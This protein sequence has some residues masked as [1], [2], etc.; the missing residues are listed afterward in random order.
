[1][2]GALLALLAAGSAIGWF[3]WLPGYRPDLRSG[4]TLGI[5][6]SHHQGRIDWRRVAGDGITFAYMKASEGADFVD[7]RFKENWSSAGAA[8]LRRGAY[9][10]FSLCSTGEDQAANFLDV[11]RT[12]TELPP[13]VDLEFGPN[14]QER[15][16]EATVRRELARYMDVIE[17][18]I[19]MQVILY[20]GHDFEERYPF[21]NELDRPRWQLGFVRRPNDQWLVWQVGSF[22]R[23][24]GVDGPVGLD[25]L[26]RGGGG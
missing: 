24:D 21:V 12:D 13:A 19:G 1:M 4:E 11:V 5:D 15:P 8:G 2:F 6:V 14:C 22:A 10:F 20:I 9:H 18:E 25:V 26:L 16:A 7:E 3:V 17:G 23:V